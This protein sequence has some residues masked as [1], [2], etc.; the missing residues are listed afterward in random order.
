MI[1]VDCLL[2]QT[3]VPGSRMLVL[4]KAPITT[5]K[6]RLE[7]VSDGGGEDNALPGTCAHTG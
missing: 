6:C 1:I 3:N 2:R 5:P 7:V 4:E